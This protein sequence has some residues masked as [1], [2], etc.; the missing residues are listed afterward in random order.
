M[1]L[2]L[3]D[4]QRLLK[5]S[6]DRFLGERYDAA[7]R[8][9]SSAEPGRWS[10]EIWLKMAELGWLGLGVPE[11]DGGFGG[12][13]IEVALV[14]EGLGRAL[15][16]EP[17]LDAVLVARLVSALGTPEQKTT[18]LPSIIDGSRRPAFAHAE[19]RQTLSRA[20]PSSS[21][22]RDGTGWRLSG[23]N[24][25]V[26]AG[27]NAD[28]L[29]VTA[30]IDGDAGLAAFLIDPALDGIDRCAFETVD[31]REGCR[32]RLEE[33]RVPDDAR[34]GQSDATATIEAAMDFARVV[35]A[36]EAV[37]CMD[38]LLAATVAYTRQREQ[39][40]RPLAANQV[41]RHRMADMSVQCEEARGIALRGALAID[42]RPTARARAASAAKFK[43]GQAGRFVAE[44]AIQCHGGMGV[45]EEL[46]IGLY[47]KRLLAIDVSF[48]TSREHLRRHAKL[49]G[50]LAD[51][52]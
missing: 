6:V 34:L 42:D 46:D 43:T 41:L 18:R 21:A 13:A 15:V 45:T 5:D 48:G 4:E 11:E 38:A 7:Q 10:R 47:A 1:N 35:L 26:G 40:G 39:F 22:T 30:T 36:S 51:A 52:A 32:I 33:V 44:Q 27:S 23:A 28:D 3:S 50:A 49:R 19:A 12:G 14:A 17:V 29:L 24:D 8:R 20:H 9:R 2:E 37:G 31:G 16:L 25:F